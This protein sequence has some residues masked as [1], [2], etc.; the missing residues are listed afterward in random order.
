MMCWWTTAFSGPFVVTVW[1]SWRMTSTSASATWRLNENKEKSAKLFCLGLGSS[2]SA[3]Y[4]HFENRKPW[5]QGCIWCH[6]QLINSMQIQILQVVC[7]SIWQYFK[8]P[9]PIWL[10][11]SV[12]KSAASVSQRSWVR[13]P[14]KHDFF[15]VLFSQ[16]LKLNTQ[17]QW[18]LDLKRSSI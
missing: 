7:N 3:P 12:G 1:T 14:F 16:L 17:V 2:F 9:A 10:D 5:K 18:N 4:C 8:W 13:I 6:R 15:Q 11:S